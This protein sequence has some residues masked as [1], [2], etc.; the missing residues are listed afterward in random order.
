MAEALLAQGKERPKYNEV[1]E[2]FEQTSKGTVPDDP[3]AVQLVLSVAAIH[4]TTDL[5][6]QVLINLAQNPDIIEP[7]R[8][9]ITSVLQE[10]GWSKTSLFKMRLLESVIKENQRMKP[11]Q[12][13]KCSS[14]YHSPVARRP[15]NLA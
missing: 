6:W 8:A 3:T 4:T 5:I 11:I 10:E 7:L 14:S 13:S 15:T 1:I 12:L 9:E 2:R